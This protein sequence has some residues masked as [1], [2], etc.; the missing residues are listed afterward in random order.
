MYF[1]VSTTPISGGFVDLRGTAL[2]NQPGSQG[3]TNMYTWYTNKFYP[4]Y[5]APLY[6]FAIGGNDSV[7]S[8]NFSFTWTKNATNANVYLNLLSMN[9]TLAYSKFY[10]Y[11]FQYTRI[12]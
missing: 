7:P 1:G 2:N 6:S 10:S 11:S 9:T 8:F 4:P 12:A 5:A 3:Q